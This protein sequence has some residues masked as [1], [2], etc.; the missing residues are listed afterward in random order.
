LAPVV[1]ELVA[2]TE[3]EALEDPHWMLAA[4]SSALGKMS[5]RHAIAARGEASGSLCRKNRPFQ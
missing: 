1:N 3:A 2:A 4:P 5:L